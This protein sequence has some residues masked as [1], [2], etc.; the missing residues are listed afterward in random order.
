MRRVTNKEQIKAG[1]IYCSFCK[2]EKAKAKWRDRVYASHKNGFACEKH[3]DLLRAE[4]EED[5]SEADYQS[6]MRI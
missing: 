4:K 1:N 3:K 5:L 6:W 2:P